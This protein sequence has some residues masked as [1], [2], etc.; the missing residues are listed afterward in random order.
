MMSVVDD[1]ILQKLWRHL[2]FY[3]EASQI[4]PLLQLRKPLQQPVEDGMD[5]R[6][7]ASY[8][9][10]S[11]ATPAGHMESMMTIFTHFT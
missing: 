8:Q 1:I 2:Q 9:A 5:H 6:L 11:E 10:L 3:Q 7:A 4:S